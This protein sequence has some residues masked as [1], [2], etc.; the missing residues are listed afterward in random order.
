MGGGR[1]D[2]VA[3]ISKKSC[4]MI[5]H[6][7]RGLSWV[8]LEMQKRE[9][10]QRRRCHRETKSQSSQHYRSPSSRCSRSNPSPEG[11]LRSG[12][13]P[14]T[15]TSPGSSTGRCARDRCCLEMGEKKIKINQRCFKLCVGL[16]FFIISI[17]QIFI[18][19][20]FGGWLKDP[21]TVATLECH[22]IGREC[23]DVM[24]TKKEEQVESN[25]FIL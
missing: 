2:R 11:S 12:P 5:R 14:R 18:F 3:T 16:K 23:A 25:F 9:E 13:G 6:R 19:Y 10:M 15:A 8:G 17:F 22:V 4:L 24:Q 7:A 1:I 20:F 21:A